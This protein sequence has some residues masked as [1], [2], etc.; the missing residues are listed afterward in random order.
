MIEREKSKSAEGLNSSVVEHSAVNRF[1]V[2]SN[3]A[4][5]ETKIVASE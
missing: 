1:A 2:G 5:D 3:P 4:W